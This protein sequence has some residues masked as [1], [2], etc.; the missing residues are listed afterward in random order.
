MTVYLIDRS[1]K[2][3]L[4]ALLFDGDRYIEVKNGI[5]KECSY[6]TSLRFLFPGLIKVLQE[7]LNKCFSMLTRTIASEVDLSYILDPYLVAKTFFVCK[8]ENV[9][10]VQCEF[11]TTTFS[12]FIVKKLLNIPLVYDA[13][14]IESVRMKG[15]SSGVN[16]S[17]IDVTERIEVTGCQISDLVFVVSDVDRMQL[18][19]W[20]IPKDKIVVIPNSTDLVEFSPLIDGTAI[21]SLHNLDGKIVLIFH[22][23]LGFAPNKE[24]IKVL[25]DSILPIISKENPSV[26]LLLVGKDPPKIS[27]FNVIVT[28]CVDNL[29]AHI[30]AA[31]LAVVPLLSG[32]GTRI[33]ILE[34]MACGKAIVS[35]IKAA[36]GLNLENERDVLLCK[37]PNSEFT[38]LVLRAIEDSNLR[39]KIGQNART[40]VENFYDW[41]KNSRKAVSVYYSL[42]YGRGAQRKLTSRYDEKRTSE[43]SDKAH[44]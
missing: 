32:G 24:A 7:G 18:L 35:T 4:S 37:Y 6:P 14:N 36:E 20:K 41:E 39:K 44:L 30:A 29:P 31:D 33:K 25:L 13:H 27:N 43:L 38:S 22:G 40:K 12:S 19:R 34:Y 17:Y 28:G 9:K 23:A 5:F 3:S 42:I 21:R 10:L 15:Y 11:P 26:R 8:K 2:K 16:A 1:I